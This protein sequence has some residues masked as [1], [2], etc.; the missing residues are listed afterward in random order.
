MQ[1]QRPRYWSSTF[2]DN[3]AALNGQYAKNRI[4]FS[5]AIVLL[6]TPYR[7]VLNFNWTHV[8]NCLLFIDIYPIYFF[9]VFSSSSS[10][11]MR[12]LAY[13][14][15]VVPHSFR[16]HM[17]TSFLP[18]YLKIILILTVWGS[19][20]LWDILI[21]SIY[22]IFS[23]FD[24]RSTSDSTDTDIRNFVDRMAIFVKQDPNTR[25]SR[26]NGSMTKIMKVISF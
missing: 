6:Q 26:L 22:F 2:D 18:P 21:E 16:I 13:Y 15:T 7:T 14:R 1:R 24:S 19:I 23:V 3:M 10:R 8:C 11:T 12:S 9:N 4:F 20:M 17:H 5:I 25:K